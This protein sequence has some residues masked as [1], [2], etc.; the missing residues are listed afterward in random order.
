MMCVWNMMVFGILLKLN[1]SMCML[2][3]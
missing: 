2:V 3:Q 1:S